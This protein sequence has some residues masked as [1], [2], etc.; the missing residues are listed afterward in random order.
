MVC[1]GCRGRAAGGCRLLS[2]AGAHAGRCQLSILEPGCHFILG[3]CANLPPSDEQ[4]AD[5]RTG[6]DHRGT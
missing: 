4:A 2:C 3:G 1:G 5:K 6:Q